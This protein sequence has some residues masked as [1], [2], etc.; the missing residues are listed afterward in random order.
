MA[1][2]MVVAIL[3]TYIG[4]NGILDSQMAGLNVNTPTLSSITTNNTA[5]QPGYIVFVGF[6]IYG[7]ILSHVLRHLTPP[8]AHTARHGQDKGIHGEGEQTGN[9]A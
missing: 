8:Q 3:M 4:F 7:F 5:L 2:V 9:R 6:V 1:D